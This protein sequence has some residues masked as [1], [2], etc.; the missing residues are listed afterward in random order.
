MYD[1]NYAKEPSSMEKSSRSANTSLNSRAQ[2]DL[3]AWKDVK[4]PGL[5]PGAGEIPKLVNRLPKEL[6]ALSYKLSQ[7]SIWVVFLG[8]TGTGKSTIFNALCGE[9]LSETGVERPKTCG[10]IVYAHRDVHIRA[11]F[12]FPEM[13][14][15]RE[16]RTDGGA[17]CCTGSFGSMMIVDHV[18]EDLAHL[19]LI[20]TPDLDS[21]EA[22]NRQI[23]E[24]LYLLS[25]VVVFVTSQEKYAD[26]VPFQFMNRIQEDG[27][28][29]YLFLNKA[30]SVLDRGEVLASLQREGL[31][32]RD[33]RFKMLPYLA[34][35]PLEHLSRHKAFLA[36]SSD[37][38]K[39]LSKTER[40]VLLEKERKYR[41]ERLSGKIQ[42]LRD[43]LD[44]EGRAVE[45]WLEQLDAFFNSTCRELFTWQEH[46]FAAETR[47]YLQQEI[48]ELYGRYDL[49]RTPR[50][51][52][53][54]L[55]RGPLRALGLG[56]PNINES[57]R[58]AL[59]RIRRQ[60]D[61][62]P[63]QAMIERFN[64][65]VLES[66]SPQDEA[67]P[68]S[69]GLRD[70]HVSLTAEETRKLVWDN[71][72]QLVLWLE[73]TF[74]RLAKGIPKSKEWGIYSTSILWGGLILSLET[75]IGGGI[76]FLEAVFDS[77]VAPF[78]TKGA[79][80]LFAYRELQMVARE[81]GER[82][83]NGMISVVR[84]QRDRYE[85]VIRSLMTSSQ[86]LEAL[87]FIQRSIADGKASML[88]GR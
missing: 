40:P 9:I 53:S 54:S 2:P 83:Q 72:D 74:D 23:V 73:G 27:K 33:D 46:H 14:I 35:G 49:L 21:I 65:L 62:A 88:T 6:C 26:D 77:A 11:G 30:D 61:V 10:P 20:D 59:L 3:F 55:I 86:T 50:R 80:E 29:Y 32:V 28:P 71:Q 69:R 67:V 79:V 56:S 38:L 76:S 85:R 87:H 41:I 12:P 43:I 57:H 34:P 13:S 1:I 45:R 4:C 70:P 31:K 51:F 22:A 17:F 37:L 75:A 39:W 24:D 84:E 18:R 64:R 42:T 47:Q 16:T 7:N 68:L 8:G 78:V 66:L 63:V 58:D 44:R 25:D 81:L 5:T 52:V 15:K 82:Y 60:I 19:I 36:G 48:R